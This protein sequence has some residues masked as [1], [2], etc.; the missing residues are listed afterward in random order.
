VNSG[1]PGFQ[2]AERPSDTLVFL[3]RPPAGTLRRHRTRTP[4]VLTSGRSA[5]VDLEI[6]AG[7]RGADGPCGP[8]YASTAVTSHVEFRIAAGLAHSRGRQRGRGRPLRLRR[9]GSG[10]HAPSPGWQYTLLDARFEGQRGRP[11]ARRRP[12]HLIRPQF[13]NVPPRLRSKRA[14]RT[15]SFVKDAGSRTS[16]G[17]GDRHLEKSRAR[18][19]TWR[20]WRAAACRRSRSFRESGRGSRHRRDVRGQAFSD[21][22]QYADLGAPGETKTVFDASPRS[23]RRRP[24]HRTS[25]AAAGD[26]WRTRRSLGVRG[27]DDDD[28]AALQKA[29]GAH[30]TV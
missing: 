4:H 15:T 7:N 20:T 23:C 21:G 24:C 13:R 22:L 8:R 6:G 9:Y 14:G 3:R 25:A 17:G 16:P 18:R 5:T 2:D 26:T 10:R 27:E 29:I 19:S 11:S 1:S 12:P 28:T 30:Q